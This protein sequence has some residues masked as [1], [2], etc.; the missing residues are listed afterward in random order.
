[1]TAVTL[2]PSCFQRE[3][4]VPE[5]EDTQVLHDV[6]FSR[7]VEVKKVRKETRVPVEIKLLLL[8]VVVITH[9]MN[10]QTGRQTHMAGWMER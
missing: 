5:G 8:H 6:E 2:S 4:G 1:M 3:R 9:L 7:L 10:R